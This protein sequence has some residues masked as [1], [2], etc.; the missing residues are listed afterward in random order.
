[1]AAEEG[2]EGVARPQVVLRT[3]GGEWESRVPTAPTAAGDGAGYQVNMFGGIAAAAESRQQELS[4][5]RRSL[6][7]QQQQ[8]QQGAVSTRR[9][10]QQLSG[11]PAFLLQD[12][13]VP[14]PQLQQVLEPLQSF[15]VL[16]FKD[17]SSIWGGFEDPVATTAFEA[18]LDRI[19]T[20][21]CC[22]DKPA[23]ESTGLPV[24]SKL[25]ISMA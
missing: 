18:W 11:P 20:S 17:A 5:S 22:R 24:K 14:L 23:M 16:R 15:Q 2:Q 21:W 19:T 13:R 3:V 1:M 6:L 4:K 12:T 7:Q 9:L 8:Q 10:Q 25:N